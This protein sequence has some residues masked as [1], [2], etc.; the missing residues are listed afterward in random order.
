VEIDQELVRAARFRA[1]LRGFLRQTE[2]VTRRS[3]LS[4]Q[5]YDLLLF[6]HAAPGHRTTVTALTRQLQLGQPAVTDLVKHAVEAGL[7]HRTRDELDRR[8]VWLEVT[9]A[10]RRL[11]LAALPSLRDARTELA[12]SLHDSD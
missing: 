10:G 2:A 12:A 5:R 4:P 11:V 3:G 1:A 6:I 7:L 9:P 8:R